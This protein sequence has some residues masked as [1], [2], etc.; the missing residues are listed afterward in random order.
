MTSSQRQLTLCGVLA[1]LFGMGQLKLISAEADVDYV[2]VASADDLE[3]RDE[4]YVWVSQP[5]ELQKAVLAGVRHIILNKHMDL[6]S[7]W[8]SAAGNSNSANATLIISASTASGYATAPHE[9]R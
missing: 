1:L 7:L 3:E 9:S 6:R 4:D 2:V 8:L 5:R